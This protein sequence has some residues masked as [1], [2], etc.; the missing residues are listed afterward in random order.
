MSVFLH[1]LLLRFATNIATDRFWAVFFLLLVVNCSISVYPASAFSFNGKERQVQ[2]VAG[3]LL[4]LE[5][6]NAADTYPESP[7]PFAEEDHLPECRLIE[8]TSTSCAWCWPP[9][10]RAL[11]LAAF[12]DRFYSTPATEVI[13]PPPEHSA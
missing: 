13:I 11:S 6:E 9:A 10:W 2:T 7:A 3:L 5:D 4:G 1:L 12:T 8:Y